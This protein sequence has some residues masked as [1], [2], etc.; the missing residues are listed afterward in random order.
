MGHDNLLTEMTEK[1]TSRGAMLSLVLT[2]RVELVGNVMVQGSPGCRDHDM[3]K[4]EF[5]RAARRA[6]SKL[7]A[8]D[9]R[10]DFG[11]SKDLLYKI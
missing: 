3:V 9:F 10:T 11:L 1:P 7:I 6:H 2:S 4:L 5:L 8:L